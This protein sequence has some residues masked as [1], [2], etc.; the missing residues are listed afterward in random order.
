M[1]V[2]MQHVV[3]TQPDI[4]LSKAAMKHIIGYLEKTTGAVGVRFSVEKTG[5]SGLSYV[6]D[7]VE[8][9]AEGDMQKPISDKYLLCIDKASY[10]FLKSMQVD[11]VKQGLNYKFVFNNPN[12][13]GAC[14]CGESFTV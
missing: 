8:S 4:A 3:D 2:V 11:Y 14:G 9:V 5:C 1:T 10:P 6:V 13:K 12:E 7:Y